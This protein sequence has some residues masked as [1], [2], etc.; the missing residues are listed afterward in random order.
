MHGFAVYNKLMTLAV[1][2]KIRRRGGSV[3]DRSFYLGSIG[4]L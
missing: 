1:S 3:Y 4:D 2:T